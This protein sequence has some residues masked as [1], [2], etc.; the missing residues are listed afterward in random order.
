MRSGPRAAA[1]LGD[2]PGHLGPDCQLRRSSTG[3]WRL[4]VELPDAVL[5]VNMP[6]E[7]QRRIEAA[8]YPDTLTLWDRVPHAV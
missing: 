7:V 1:M 3:T 4:W 8:T 2:L 6:R 5:E